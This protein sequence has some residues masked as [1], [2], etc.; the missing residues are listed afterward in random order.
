MTRSIILVAVPLG[1]SLFAAPV[2]ARAA[3]FDGNWS[4]SIITEKGDC[5]AGYRYEIRIAAGKVSYRGDGAFDLSGSVTRHGTVKVTIKRGQQSA[6]AKG[7][8][9]ANSG[10]GTW[11][12]QNSTGGCVGR[13]QAERR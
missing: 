9:S 11:I 2:P 8:L 3:S 5:D 7:R 6:N 10:R 1:L 4:V 12:G 13:W